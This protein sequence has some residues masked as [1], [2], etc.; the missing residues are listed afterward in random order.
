MHSPE[1]HG[2]AE[3]VAIIG[4]RGRFPGADSV[5]QV[6]KNL[7]DGVE[8]IVTFSE[9]ELR[10]TRVDAATM[11]LPGFVNRGSV[12]SRMEDFDVQF[13]GISARDAE[14]IDPQQRLFL[15]C[16]WGASR[17][18]ATTTTPIPGRS[19][20]MADPIRD[21]TCTRSTATGRGISTCR[22]LQLGTTRTT[23][24]PRCRTDGGS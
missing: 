10:E 18:R 11:K 13:F 7:C 20:C 6:R 14:V 23:R 24:P 22:W 19:G 17:R 9:Q 8:S 1:S 2:P 12:L 5:E 21:R 3:S 4:M 15:E 16:A